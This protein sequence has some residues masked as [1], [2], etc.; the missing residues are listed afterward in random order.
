MKKRFIFVLVIL[1]MMFSLM[2]CGDK[3]EQPAKETEK[4][5]ATGTEKESS[6]ESEE[7]TETEGIYTYNTAWSAQPLNWNP[8]SWENSNESDFMTYTVAPFVYYTFRPNDEEGWMY[9]Y[10]AATSVKDITADYADKEKYGVPADATEQY[11]YEI[12][13]REGMKWE[14]GDEIKADDYIESA[15]FLLDPMMKNYRSNTYISG[16]SAI[17]NAQ[18]YFNND[19]AG[20][21][22]YKNV[23]ENGADVSEGKPMFLTLTN[24]VAF[25]G[26]EAKSYYEDDQ[27]KEFFVVNGVDLFEKYKDEYVPFT[28]EMITEL[29]AASA[30]F[31][32][33]NP[34]A[35]KEW[36]VYDSGEVY[37]E[38][39]WEKVGVV[40]VDD[41]TILYIVQNPIQPF[42]MHSA[43]SSSWLV[44]IPTYTKNIKEV[45]GLKASEYGTSIETTM[46]CG[47]YKIK[48]F[49]KD[50]QIILERNEYYWAFKDGKFNPENGM[51]RAD[52]VVIDIVEDPST[53][54]QL[55]M[56]G[57]V[58]ELGLDADKMVQFKKSDRLSLVDETFTARYIFA[59]DLTTLQNR[60]KEK[61]SGCRAMFHLK[62][63]RKA[64]SR[65]ID[66]T[67]YCQEA[68][69]GFKPAFYLLNN[70][71]YYDMANNPD[72]VYRKSSYAKKA[73][74][75]LYEV[76]YTDETIDAEYKK[77]T[78]RD[79]EEAKALFQAAYDKAIEMGIYK[80]GQDVPFEIM[81]TPAELTP[82][83][84]KQSELLQNY[85]NEGTM[86][87][88]FEGKIKVVF[89]SGD[90]KRYDNVALGKNM[91]IHGAWGGAAFYPFSVIRL[92]TNPGYMGGLEKIHESNGWNPSVETLEMTI[93][94]A[95]GTTVTETRTFEDW[96]N[97]INGLGEY[98]KN[99]DEQLQVL[100]Q[101]ERGVLEAYQCIPLGT[102]TSASLLSYKVDYAKED[103]NLM[104]G[105]G[106]FRFLKFNYTDAE[107][108][109]FVEENN[110][111]LNYE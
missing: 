79:L 110:G 72:S 111:Q 27:Y 15:K 55:F 19:K 57:N 108:K 16:E 81:V 98:A 12:K 54:E 44:H 41:Y 48:S 102:Y 3:T 49:E 99:A 50:K 39:P 62:D 82:Q 90:K 88:P 92:Y 14:N 20:K 69:S 34:E 60:D 66:R 4:T 95:D 61:G 10:D 101:L 5:E 47:P 31:G 96:S 25:F 37:P 106:G 9:G 77:V 100:A 51:Y 1:V 33:K 104:Y 107:W 103:Y 109:A 70:L 26:K 87:T 7:A 86:G 78:G 29:N 40:K 2:A 24:P 80:D 21:P 23:V 28:D 75:D 46:S 6:S 30:A 89:E 18:A 42:Y 74:L 36:L 58:D 65:S 56:Q 105:F 68:T 22:V 73:V 64:V 52:E 43:L 93:N 17:A 45:G 59:T 97:Q 83:H 85:L 38:T 53:K 32:D 84:Q 11:V 67:E 8:H 13:L 71:Y 35:Y 63:F 76:E 94:R 91:A